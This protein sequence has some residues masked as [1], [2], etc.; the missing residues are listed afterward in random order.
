VRIAPK[1]ARTI[2]DLGTALL[3][4]N[5]VDRAISVLKRAIAADPNRSALHSNLGY[6]LQQKRD[7]DGAV[8]EYREAIRLDEKLVS[9]WINLATAVAQRGDRAEARRALEKAQKIDPTDPRV[10]ANLDELRD[11]EKKGPFD[12]GVRREA[13]R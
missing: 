2:S 10:K 4:D 13:G 3:A 7:L 1:D 12:G 9:A 6:A 5:Q 8:A 11:L